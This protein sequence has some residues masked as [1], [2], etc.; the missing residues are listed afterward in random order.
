[1]KVVTSVNLTNKVPIKT[2]GYISIELTK[3]L[4]AVCEVNEVDIY[5]VKGK[6]RFQNLIT[7]K[8]EYGYLARKLTNKS[9]A[10]IGKEIDRDH[11]NV[12]Y[13]N[14]KIRGWL[15]IKGYYMNEKL[16]LIR[17]RLKS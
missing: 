16:E 6:R 5:D 11:A 14:R 15:G 2:D 3:I 12:L 1:M 17:E 8:R 13:H 10:E 9:L 4:R 7:A